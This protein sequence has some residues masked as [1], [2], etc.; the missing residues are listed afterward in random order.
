MSAATPSISKN[1]TYS[2]FTYG[3]SAAND[4]AQ[5]SANTSITAGVD[6]AAALNDG[7]YTMSRDYTQFNG[8]SDDS[9]TANADASQVKLNGAELTASYVGSNSVKVTVGGPTASAT[10]AAMPVYYACSNLKKTKDAVKDS[11]GQY[12]SDAKDAK[13]VTS[14]AASNSKTLTV[15][16][17]R[18]YWMGAMKTPLAEFTSVS[19][20]EAGENTEKSGLVKSLKSSPDTTLEVPAGSYDVV[21]ITQNQVTSVISKAQGNF[22]IGGNF[23][24]NHQEVNV[25]GANGFTAIK[26]HVYHCNADWDKDTLTISYK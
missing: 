18:A 26:Y 21:I 22:E 11:E 25:E 24:K 19:I 7:N 17:A 2:G 1:R 14:S 20:R 23:T 6:V 12:K 15:T 8:A 4:N 13:K 16:G 3:Y 5:D 9:A 10:F